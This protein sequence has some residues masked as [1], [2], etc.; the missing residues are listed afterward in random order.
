MTA[1]EL[2]LIVYAILALG[3]IGGSVWVGAHFTAQHYQIL[4]AKDHA[5]EAQLAAAAAQA[6]KAQQDAA[7]AHNAE[8]Q[9]DLQTQLSSTRSLAGDFA[10]RLRRAEQAASGNVSK[11]SGRSGALDTSQANRSDRLTG[12]LSDAAG[13]CL[14]NEARQDALIAEL[15]PQLK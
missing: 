8:I 3:V 13:E 1:L 12:L 14:A 5:A 7:D 6:A 9:R 15:A 2:R 4:I 11:G 10:L